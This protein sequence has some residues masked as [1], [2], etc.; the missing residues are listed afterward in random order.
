MKRIAHIQCYFSVGIWLLTNFIYMVQ[1][2]AADCQPGPPGLI[3]WWRGEGNGLDSAG[4]SNG[5]LIG[6][7]GFTNGMVRRGFLFSGAGDD[8]VALPTNLFPMPAVDAVGNIPFSFETW[9]S[10]V[11]QGTILGQQDLQPFDPPING[12]VLALYVGTNGYLYAEMF[13][14]TDTL[15]Q[16]SQPVADGKFHH[17]AITYDGTREVLYLDGVAIAS[18]SFSQQGYSYNYNYQLGTGWSDGWDQTPGG[19]FPFNGIV[20][21]PSLYARALTTNEVLS[22]FQ[23]GSSGKCAPPDGP[24]LVHRFSFNE[25]SGSLLAAD[26]VSGSHGLLLFASTNAPYTNGISDGSGFSGG[27]QLLLA[28]TNGFVKFP[29]RMISWLSNVTLE[30]WVTWNGPSTSVWQR[31]WDF[32]FNDQGTNTSGIGTN[33]FIFSPCRGGTELLGFEETIVNPYGT[34]SDPNSLILAGTSRMP[35]GQPTYIAVTYDPLAGISSLYMNAQLLGSVHRQLNQM[36]HFAD[37]N[38]WLGRSQWSRDPFFSGRYEE[39]RIWEG[40]LSQ[41]EISNHHS[42]GPDQQFVRLRPFLFLSQTHGSAV[43]SWA[44]YYGEGFQL[45]TSS[46]LAFPNW[47]AVTNSITVTNSA[48]RVSIPLTGGQ[49]F[50]RL[51]H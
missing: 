47:I 19:W 18:S 43:I 44:T 49:A 1:A 46:N 9:F 51:K 38:N 5:T 30:A 34:E 3:A 21:E 27:G 2:Q 42:S 41:E 11:A 26:S 22:L 48:Y 13:W 37:Y 15:L 24:A 36:K 32:G 50:Y 33:Y 20:D 45:Q 40:V 17:V 10:T 29:P 39:F 28:G 16:S 25:P 35:V 8:Y 4:L 6:G 31:V 14:G 23:A 7:G 12:N